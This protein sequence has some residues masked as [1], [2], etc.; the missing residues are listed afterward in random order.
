MLSLWTRSGLA[1]AY[2]G[3]LDDHPETKNAVEQLGF[4]N[5]V[6]DG[7][8]QYREVHGRAHEADGSPS[9]GR[10]TFPQMKKGYANRRTRHQRTSGA[11]T[12]LR[13]RGNFFGYR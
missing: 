2:T 10:E 1:V 3:S 6:Q 5:E 13:Q 8:R 11:A 12:H 7:I 4:L 9:S